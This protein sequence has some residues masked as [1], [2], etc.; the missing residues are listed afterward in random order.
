MSRHM[1]MVVSDSPMWRGVVKFWNGH[2]ERYGPYPTRMGAT[3]AINRA[4]KEDAE[5]KGCAYAPDPNAEAH[6]TWRQIRVENP[7]WEPA[8]W[9]R[10]YAV[11]WVRE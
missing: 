8:T 10:E 9:W 6:Q 1:R 11:E 5:R 7:S 4:L 3:Q 2:T